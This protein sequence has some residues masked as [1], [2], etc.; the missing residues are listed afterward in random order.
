MSENRMEILI[1]N[2]LSEI[3]TKTE[4]PDS[5]YESWLRCEVGMTDD[6]MSYLK[7]RGLFPRPCE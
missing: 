4:I 5:Q 6:E 3:C 1:N 7:E 2:L